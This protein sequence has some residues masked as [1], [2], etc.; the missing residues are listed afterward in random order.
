MIRLTL[1]LPPTANRYYRRVGRKTLISADGR[2][3]KQRCGLVAAAQV[4]EPLTGEV[5]ITGTVYMAR[6]G[7]DLDNR[8][9]PL[10]DGIEGYAF[11]NDGQVARL[12]LTRDLD[13]GNPRVE[14]TITE[15]TT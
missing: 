4:P 8:I 3:Y 12:D 2:A 5:E 7:C 10:L 11:A 13:H 1:P 15:R 6:R 9:K 14:I